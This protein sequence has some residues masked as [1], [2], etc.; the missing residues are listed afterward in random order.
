MRFSC[1]PQGNIF[2]FNPHKFEISVYQDT[3]PLKKLTGKSELFV[4]LR[5]PD[6]SAERIALR[7]PFL[8]ILESGER[9]YVTVMRPDGEGPNDLIVYENDKPIATL[10][11][12][13]M[14]RAVDLQGRLYCAVETDFPKLIRYIVSEK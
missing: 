11:M 4:P 14:A 10:P 1:T 5:V 3:R 8:T 7:F 6:A 9:L 2:L 12:A 13:G